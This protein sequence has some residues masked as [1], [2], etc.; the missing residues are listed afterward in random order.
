MTTLKTIDRIVETLRK[1]NLA[2]LLPNLRQDVLVWSTLNNPI[3]YEKFIQSKP[4][5]SDFVAED[6]SPSKLSLIALGQPYITG[7]EPKNLLDS[8]DQQVVKN[9]L[10]GFNDQTIFEVVPQDLASAGSIAL[11]LADLHRSSS[12][13]I[14]LLNTIPE[15]SYGIWQAPLVCLFG[16]VDDPD[17]LLN[18]LVQPGA[19]AKRYKL[20]IHM[21]LSN[22]LP[23]NTQI[24]TLMGLCYGMYGDLL[25]APDRLSLVQE[26]AQQ[27]P[28]LAMD[29]SKRWL[30]IH[31]VM[32]N[33]NNLNHANAAANIDQLT[34]ILFQIKITEISGEAKGLA[35]LIEAG[36][37]LTHRTYANWVNQSIN[38]QS[39]YQ[40]DRPIENSAVIF[41]KIIQLSEQIQTTDPLSMNTAEMALTLANL[42]YLEEA[43]K[44]L[45]QPGDPRLDE[46]ESVYAIAKVSVQAENHQRTAEAAA[47]ITRLLDQQVSLVDV[48]VFGD[49]FSLVNLGKLLNNLNKP[50]EASKI[51]GLGLQ[52]CPN[53]ADLLI[54]L[55]DSYK[56]SRQ[57]QPAAD[58]LQVLV[59]LNPDHSGYRRDY[60][61]ALEVTGNWEAGLKERSIILGSNPSDPK[62]L[63]LDDNY[64][65]AH[66]ALKANRPELA[67]NVC[68]SILSSNPEASQALIYAGEA[69]LQMNETDKG[70]E[71]LTQATQVAPHLAETW[72][73]L[74]NAQKKISPLETVIDTLKNA[75]QAVPNSPRIHFALGDLYLED[76]SPTLAL[77][78]LQSALELSPDD[79]QILASYGKAL[80]LIGHTEEA[81]VTLSKAYQLEPSLPGLARM[82]ANLLLD[83]GQ[84][85]QAIAPLELLIESKSNNDPSLYMDYARCVLTLC[86]LGSTA[87]PP[88][89]A[90][91]AL[92]EVLQLDPELAEAKALTA[93]A[94]AINGENEMAFQAFREALDTPLTEDKG[95]FERLS[96][97][98]GSVASLIGKH[99]VAIAALHEAGQ[100]NPTN[101]AIFKALSDAYFSANLPEDAVR[102]ARNVLV[103]DGENP[104]QLSWFAGQ[105]AKFIRNIKA[106]SSNPALAL[107]KEL[108]DEALSSL[109]KAMQ[110]A[111]TRI[112]L[113]LQLGDFHASIGAQDEAKVIFASIASLDFVTV[114]D[115]KSA[116]EYLS[117]MDDHASAIECL[118][119]GIQ[120][121]QDST[122]K[123]NASLYISLA[124][125]YVR[126]HDDTSAINTLDK[127]IRIIPDSSSLISLKIE[128][129]LGLGQ[130]F[131]ALH[132]IETALH[133]HTDTS[134]NVD[135]LFLASRI[136]RCLG[137]FSSTVKYARMAVDAAHPAEFR[138]KADPNT[139]SISN[140]N[141]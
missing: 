2:W 15:K 141:C 70:V 60:A 53:D 28:Q 133:D 131:E 84:I 137:D 47:Q 37:L 118:E 17:S 134:T 113:L 18:A 11:A 130:S 97:G 117:R 66:C 88:M 93:E 87:N 101:P 26:L 122:D 22:P 85:E 114:D 138:P 34:E 106:D 68:G 69:H 107:L 116:S 98:F 42:G 92:N 36:N 25:P 5:E 64:A 100:V 108:P 10:R 82:Y 105:V 30:E 71:Y 128:I 123:H 136:N 125:E 24:A 48:P 95:W 73:A 44:L 49:G 126:N 33:R 94:L 67:L 61:Q 39:K 1:S 62:S 75:S 65:Y 74:A 129:L 40:D 96:F 111:P 91:I 27:R 135:L 124:H 109:N 8:I 140:A 32:A 50:A 46:I 78:D 19:G 119:K 14:G 56:S 52:T 16:L 13:W 9:A 77:P 72:L 89:K 110:L 58:T 63:P 83:L 79:P 31:P 80:K 57:H 81:R 51:F 55:A 112:D 139:Y 4:A 29:F 43:T 115:L 38:L 99:D 35:E 7:I 102:T 132:C 23:A 3:F 59:T 86:K 90:L 121:D 21:L 6:F 76:N 104:D 127:A 120:I 20:A 103:I 12:S 41:E 45:P 54:L